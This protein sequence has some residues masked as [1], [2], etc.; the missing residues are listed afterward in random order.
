MSDVMIPGCSGVNQS[1]CG[2][3]GIVCIVCKR[4]IN[5]LMADEYCFCF[6]LEKRRVRVVVESPEHRL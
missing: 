1:Y 6:V 5:K 4:I 3:Y 2:L